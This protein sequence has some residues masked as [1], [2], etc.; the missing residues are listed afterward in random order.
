M[1]MKIIAGE[2]E[3]MEIKIHKLFLHCCGVMW[4]TGRTSS[5]AVTVSSRPPYCVFS[6]P[7]SHFPISNESHYRSLSRNCK[8]TVDTVQCAIC[9]LAYD[10]ACRLKCES[11]YA[12]CFLR[13]NGDVIL[14]FDWNGNE[15][16]MVIKQKWK[17][18]ETGKGVGIKQE[19][20]CN[21]TGWGWE[22][23]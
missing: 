1:E 16:G 2:W 5:C 22:W 23:E 21:E 8:N 19:W 9:A 14:K 6:F 4:P 12:R 20:E 10:Q 18:N 15:T 3:G 7:F 11:W 13:G 17:W